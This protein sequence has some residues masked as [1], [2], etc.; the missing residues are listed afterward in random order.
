MIDIRS[1][2][3]A[4]SPGSTFGFYAVDYFAKLQHVVMDVHKDVF[5]IGV[6]HRCFI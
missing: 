1:D 3:V 5:D 4:K 6:R 2:D